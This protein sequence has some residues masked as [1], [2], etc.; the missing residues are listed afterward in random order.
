MAS[1]RVPS[2]STPHLKR[3]VGLHLDLEARG[4]HLLEQLLHP[5]V[6]PQLVWTRVRVTPADVTRA[7]VI[8]VRTRVRGTSMVG[9]RGG[10]V[11][12]RTVLARVLGAV[13]GGLGRVG[14]RMGTRRGRKR[15][16]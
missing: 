7:A 2:T 12:R 5:H 10:A 13:G 11:G 15:C 1:V 14:R 9:R 4:R 8:R 16:T 3:A 6:N